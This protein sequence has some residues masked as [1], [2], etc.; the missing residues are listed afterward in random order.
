[1]IN[2][3][4]VKNEIGSSISIPLNNSQTAP[5]YITNIDGLGPV[6]ANINTS[7]NGF[8]DGSN[9][10]SSSIPQRDISITIGYRDIDLSVEE[11][12]NH[13][14]SVLGVKSLVSLLI[15]TDLRTY[16]IDGYIES[17][18][19]IIWS[20]VC[21]AIVTIIC[22]DPF[23]RTSDHIEATY[24][25]ELGVKFP[26]TT[27]QIVFANRFD[28]VYFINNMTSQKCYPTITITFVDIGS[29]IVS[30][31]V[32]SIVLSYFYND[33][34][35]TIMKI[36]FGEYVGSTFKYDDWAQSIEKG[37]QLI[38]CS[39]PG[40][41]SI[42]LRSVS[43]NENVLYRLRDLKNWIEIKPNVDDDPNTSKIV[44]DFEFTTGSEKPTVISTIAWR[45]RYESI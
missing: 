40:K 12:R 43:K 41:K 16:R 44:I 13:L 34:I 32:K 11:L 5:Y 37:D 25:S 6:S 28:Y 26:I 8:T 10:I 4:T 30:K 35:D 36:D 42:R 1:M 38:V 2:S 39:E 45:E 7:E 31:K 27:N 9:Y 22:P 19:Q 21:G 17:N 29:S 15:E 14:V 23:F 24:I 3:V 33:R 20:S 18:E